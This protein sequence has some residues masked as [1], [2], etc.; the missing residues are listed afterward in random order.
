MEQKK[1]PRTS[2]VSS[3]CALILFGGIALGAPAQSQTAAPDN[4][5]NNKGQQ[6]TAEQ[7]SGQT[8][9]R[10]LTAKIRRSVVD[11][12]SLSTYAH[13]VKIITTNGAVTLKGPVQSEQEK[14]QIAEKAAAIV[15]PNK[16][17]NQLTVKQ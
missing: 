5:G 14:Q 10:D 7:Q 11:D 12:K 3:C 13:N 15:G 2:W 16:V 6:V 4:S 1:R 8:S 9:D 17:D